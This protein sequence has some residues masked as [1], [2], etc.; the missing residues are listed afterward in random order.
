MHR[1][2]ECLIFITLQKNISQ[3]VNRGLLSMARI[4]V[5]L[6]CDTLTLS[7]IKLENLFYGYD[8]INMLA[9]PFFVEVR[10]DLSYIA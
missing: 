8:Y 10:L 6:F 1:L 9:Y 7:L 4:L 2:D 3:S 5:I